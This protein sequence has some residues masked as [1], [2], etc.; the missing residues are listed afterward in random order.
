MDCRI[1]FLREL[2]EYGVIRVQWI[3]SGENPSDIFT[4]NT[5]KQTFLKYVKIIC[6]E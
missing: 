5:D 4:K 6:V 1:I 3:P 2:K